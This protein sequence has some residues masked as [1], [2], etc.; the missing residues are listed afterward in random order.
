MALQNGSVADVNSQL[1]TLFGFDADWASR[2]LPRTKDSFVKVRLR[3]HELI[4]LGLFARI[5]HDELADQ[6]EIIDCLR[7]HH[8]AEVAET[9]KQA[10]VAMDTPFDLKSLPEIWVIVPD[11]RHDQ[12]NRRG[13]HIRSLLAHPGPI[14]FFTPD[15]LAEKCLQDFFGKEALN[16]KGTAVQFRDDTC[17][18]SQQPCVLSYLLTDDEHYYHVTE[19]KI[20]RDP[21]MGKYAGNLRFMLNRH[22]A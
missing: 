6:S 14:T 4:Q 19:Q 3:P 9:V 11:I 8:G 12:L 21:R 2:R 20:I 17:I 7:V 5:L 16:A 18:A 15:F 22:A 13:E 1:L 10:F